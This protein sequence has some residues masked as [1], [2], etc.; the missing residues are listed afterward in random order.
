MYA[1]DRRQT[2]GSLNASALWER[3]HNKVNIVRSPLR[4]AL[5]M[6]H[7]LLLL[8][9]STC[10]PSLSA[11]EPR[12]GRIKSWLAEGRRHANPATY[13]IRKLDGSDDQPMQ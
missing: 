4:S 3:R 2:K 7:I 10:R 13:A 6:K 8:S 1:T 11:L 9:I 5:S 12:L